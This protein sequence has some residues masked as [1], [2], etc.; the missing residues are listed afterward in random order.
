MFN[1]KVVVNLYIDG[2]MSSEEYLIL[3]PIVLPRK[4]IDNVIRAVIRAK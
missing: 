1:D 3:E 2:L 4:G